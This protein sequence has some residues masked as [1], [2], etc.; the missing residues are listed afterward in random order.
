M[1]FCCFYGFI[2]DFLSF[3][4]GGIFLKTKFSQHIASSEIRILNT[5]K[6]GFVKAGYFLFY[7]CKLAYFTAAKK[8]ILQIS[9]KNEL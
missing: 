4:F 1:C 8:L 5:E 9:L 7:F 3:Y 6:I 2:C